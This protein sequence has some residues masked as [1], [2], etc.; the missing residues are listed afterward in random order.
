MINE[1]RVKELYEIA[2]YDA[3]SE[4]KNRQMGMYYRSDY[5][6]KE[7]MKSVFTGTIAFALCIVL[8][9]LYD[10]Q[11]I[12]ESI[13]SLDIVAVAVAFIIRYILFMAVYLVITYV[14][15]YRRY[16]RGRK[17]LKTYYGHLKKVNKLYDRE[18]KLK[19]K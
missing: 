10:M 8:W 9:G 4:E 6:S 14:V 17:E 3:C 7:M 5:I 18:E 11:N 12:L 16:S 1:E 19:I 15:A 2:A 13:N